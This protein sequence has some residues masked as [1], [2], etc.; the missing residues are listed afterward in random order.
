MFNDS[1][2]V[3]KLD[4]G[5]DHVEFVKRIPLDPRKTLKQKIKKVKKE[6]IKQQ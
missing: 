3:P 2:F 6:I 5:S 4:E 1:N